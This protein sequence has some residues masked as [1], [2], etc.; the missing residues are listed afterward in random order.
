MSA[1]PPSSTST[2]GFVALPDAV[3][4]R[5]MA[6]LLS[7]VDLL[8]LATTSQA[9]RQLLL[10][11]SLWRHRPV[12]CYRTFARRS[13]LPSL[14]NVVHQLR[15]EGFED[16]PRNWP[17]SFS[18]LLLFPHLRY[19]STVHQA[20]T[21]YHPPLSCDV[22]S[23][24]SLRHLTRLLFDQGG[25]L[26]VRDLKLLATLPALASFTAE[27][28]HFE[29]GDH[30]TL[31]EWLSVSSKRQGIKR[32]ASEE[33]E[34]DEDGKE[35][36]EDEQN[37]DVDYESREDS[38]NSLSPQRYSPLLLFLHALAAKPSFV[39]LSLK[40]CDLTPFVLEHM[41]V[42]PHLRCF[43]L[44][45]NDS[46]MRSYTFA[47]VTV[48]FPSLTSLSTSVCSDKAI[49]H[50]LQLPRL[51][52]L[53]FPAYDTDDDGDSVST[54]A[55]GFAALGQATSLRALVYSPPEGCDA[56][57][58]LL[59]SLTAVM[60]IAHL[61]RLTVN[62]L[63]LNEAKCVQLFSLRLEHLRCLELIEQY[64]SGYHQ[65]PQTNS[66]LLPFVKP[67]GF[68]V[69]GRA[70]RQAARA[71]NRGEGR[72]ELDPDNDEGEDSVIPHDNAANFPALECLA[73]PYTHYNYRD[74]GVV[75][76]WTKAQLRRSYEFEKVVEWEAE[77]ATLGEAE[78][79]KT[80]A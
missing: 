65:C 51:E 37:S 13:T 54:T 71:A 78:L 46:D 68:L 63:W 43:A 64:G 79:L 34:K 49:K 5:A 32:K 29:D 60:T 72:R 73:L 2:A 69:P 33:E 4:I 31:N 8:A 39:H 45:D 17:W 26:A 7:T 56:D 15:V 36:E 12:S 10:S 30:D 14:R 42:W 75:G 59:A 50:L 52:E 44:D 35:E 80:L 47:Q 18:T 27:Y 67:A 70:E 41:P 11:P 40:A 48:H 53:R 24:V 23:L 28:M 19:L 3:L 38:T 1:T 20:L 66:A 61:T 22:T 25:Q 16:V 21:A 57:T 74:C 62:A 58:P 55:R 6:P 76:A 77:T 9:T